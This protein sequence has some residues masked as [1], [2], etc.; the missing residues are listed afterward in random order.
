M[1]QDGFV[2]E[3]FR[4][5][6]RAFKRNGELMSAACDEALDKGAQLIV[7]EAQGNLRRNGTNVTGLLRK[8]GRAE[9]LRD[10]EYQAG[11]FS[12]KGQGYAEYVENGRRSGKMPPYEVIGAWFYKRFKPGDWKKAYSIGF[13]IARNI[14]KKGT[15]PHPFFRPAVESQKHF[16][17]EEI[18]KA[19]RQIL[20][21]P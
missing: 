2:V 6:E 13:A 20:R 16:I 15:K 11:F 9:R 8:S 18:T 21:K 1:E 5:L 3:N 19:A 17:V 7:A 12:K 10:G 14:A 4:E